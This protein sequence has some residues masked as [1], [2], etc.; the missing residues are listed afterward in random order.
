M[1]LFSSSIP[2]TI[3][4]GTAMTRHQIPGSPNRFKAKKTK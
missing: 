3:T 2:K 1:M 4:I